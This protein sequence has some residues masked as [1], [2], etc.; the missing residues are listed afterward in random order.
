MLKTLGRDGI[1]EMVRRHCEGA[2]RLAN[3]L[4]GVPGV[5]VLNRVSLNQI[6]LV[7]EDAGGEADA[8]TQE[9]ADRMND[10]E[11]FVRTAVWRGRVILRLS[12]IE[13]ETDTG[14]LDRLGRKIERV[15]AATRDGWPR[16]AA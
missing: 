4:S 15:W 7:F 9:V 1:A 2:Q 11:H 10:A 13:G 14:A 8:L 12:I 6:A 16:R 5:R 3:H